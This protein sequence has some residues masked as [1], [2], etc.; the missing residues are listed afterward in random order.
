MALLSQ[1]FA[2]FSP[3]LTRAADEP[4]IGEGIHAA[5]NTR[6][7][8]AP[9]DVR[10]AEAEGPKPTIREV[11]A[12]RS[13]LYNRLLLE[14]VL[15]RIEKAEAIILSYLLTQDD[16]SAQIGPYLV[17][18]EADHSLDVTKTGDDDGWRQSYFPE[19]ETIP[20]T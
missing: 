7:E 5:E 16:T 8:V 3:P 12:I 18:V 17:E 9:A 6:D 10:P 20:M 4:E 2:N 1:E 13:L 14:A 15:R 11:R 19:I